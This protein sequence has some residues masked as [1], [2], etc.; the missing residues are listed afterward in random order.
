M[1]K[2]TDNTDDLCREFFRLC[3]ESEEGGGGKLSEAARKQGGAST[4]KKILTEMGE[5]AA[6]ISHC[7]TRLLTKHQNKTT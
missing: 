7:Q 1:A 4:V 5:S 3:V 2:A 6:T